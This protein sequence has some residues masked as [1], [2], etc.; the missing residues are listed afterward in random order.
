VL[1]FDDEVVYV[2][3]NAYW[4]NTWKSCW[5]AQWR[6]LVVDVRWHLVLCLGR[7]SA[8][9]SF[10]SSQTWWQLPRWRQS[11]HPLCSVGGTA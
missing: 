3:Q 6:W 2:F 1:F 11:R 10:A 4:V 9:S 7:F 8:G 5:R